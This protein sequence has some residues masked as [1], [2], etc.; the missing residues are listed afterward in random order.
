MSVG[1]LTLASMFESGGFGAGIVDGNSCVA[2]LLAVA[3]RD[4]HLENLCRAR[5]VESVCNVV[6]IL[7]HSEEVLECHCDRDEQCPA[8]G[9]TDAPPPRRGHLVQ[10]LVDVQTL[11]G[12]TSSPAVLADGT[13][14]DADL[15]GWSP[16]ML[17]GK[18]C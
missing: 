12:L 6:E 4:R 5:V 10:I 1:R 17:S 11:L 15:A 7:L 18:R 13:P 2:G 8:Y 16:R 9:N 3:G 14:L